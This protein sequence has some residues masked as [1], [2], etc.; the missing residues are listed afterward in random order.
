[1]QSGNTN[2]RV[3]NVPV[4]AATSTLKVGDKVSKTLFTDEDD[5]TFYRV[6]AIRGTIF[7]TDPNGPFEH[8]WKGDVNKYKPHPT[9]PGYW[10]LVRQG[11]EVRAALK[12]L[13]GRIPV[14]ASYQVDLNWHGEV[15]K[16]KVT[17]FSESQVLLK[18]AK[19]IAKAKLTAYTP[20][21]IHNYMK[22]NDTRVTVK[23]L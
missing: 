1:M 19:Q 5:A 2:V 3:M 22:N 15:I 9:Y 18:A 7:E 20:W 11:V 12:A 14:Q 17:A 4:A 13:A 8:S 23:Q 10:V 21:H 6:K 16:I